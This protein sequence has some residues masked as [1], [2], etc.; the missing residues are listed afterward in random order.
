MLSEAAALLHTTEIKAF[1]NMLIMVMEM[2]KFSSGQK[3]EDQIM[4]IVS[5]DKDG[6]EIISINEAIKECAILANEK[7]LTGEKKSKYILKM[8]LAN[9]KSKFSDVAI[10][11]H[12]LL[13][14]VKGISHLY[15]IDEEERL[16]KTAEAHA[17]KAL[18][19]GCN[20]CGEFAETV[21]G[22]CG[23]ARYCCR[24]HQKSDWKK[25]KIECNESSI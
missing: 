2:V 10:L 4:S 21:C 25:H 24:E 5:R 14:K 8:F 20:V 11:K 19:K 13:Q 18:D 23:I 16:I 12:S 6:P 22:K 3:K 17:K 1:E 15:G 9:Y 7:G